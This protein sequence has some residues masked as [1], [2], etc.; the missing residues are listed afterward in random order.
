MTET[1]KIRE[2][3]LSGSAEIYEDVIMLV[4][5]IQFH[6]GCI[7]TRAQIPDVDWILNMTVKISEF[8]GSSG[9]GV[10]F[11]HQMG[12]DGSLNGGPNN[13]R[14]LALIFSVRMDYSFELE[15]FE[16][17]SMHVDWWPGSGKSVKLCELEDPS[18]VSISIQFVKNELIVYSND[19]LAMRKWISI[20]IKDNWIGITAQTN[21]FVSRIDLC[22]L[23]VDLGSYAITKSKFTPRKAD[24]LRVPRVFEQSDEGIFLRNAAFEKTTMYMIA[25]IKGG[26]EMLFDSS[27]DEV[28]DV[29]DEVNTAENDVASF[30]ELNLFITEKL[31]P[32]CQKWQIR[33][34][35]I[36]DSVEKS[37]NASDVAWHYT[38]KMLR[39]FN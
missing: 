19:T 36:I 21:K 29:I 6:Q 1:N 20:D 33:S 26:P 7:W 34:A 2:W 27:V 35:S 30:S 32:F 37:K 28:F 25:K 8:S 15:V 38:Q 24:V 23:V 11:I 3:E 10:W 14:G 31:M 17:E 18:V 22:S 9:F 4:P 39:V 13:F 5:P 12:L 16:S